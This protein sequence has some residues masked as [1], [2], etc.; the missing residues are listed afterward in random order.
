MGEILGW[1]GFLFTLFI[2]GWVLWDML[3]EGLVTVLRR[4]FWVLINVLERLGAGMFW[5]LDR[6]LPR[7][8]PLAQVSILSQHRPLGYVDADDED[9]PLSATGNTVAGHGD[10][11]RNAIAAGATERNAVLSR[12]V[13]TRVQADIIT[14][15]LRA[16]TLYIPDGKGGHKRLGQ[17]DL[18]RLAT[19]LSPNGRAD[20]EYG[21]LRAELEE[22]NRPTVTVRD[23]D[24]TRREVAK[25]AP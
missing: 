21:Q 5:V 20:S 6:V 25:G 15:L 22:L 16:E 8:T 24:G 13:V 7:R 2:A 17:T 23:R 11:G 18:I 4:T 1:A 14:R 9:E 12:N 10:A 3:P 19:G